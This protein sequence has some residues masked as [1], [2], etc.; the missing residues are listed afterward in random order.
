MLIEEIDVVRSETLQAPVHHSLDVIGPTVQTALVGEVEA[1][2]RG[3]LHLIA[4][5]FECSADDRL[6]GVRAIHFC[7]IEE[8]N[9][10][11]VGLTDDL[12]GIIDRKCQSK[13]MVDR[14][15]LFSG[16]M[17]EF[18]SSQAAEPRT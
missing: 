15:L 4:K 3:D 2:L 12:D 16:E 17:Q 8:Y 7:C 6:T 14:L 11:I 13:H 10:P 1:E 18:P 5:R 9:A